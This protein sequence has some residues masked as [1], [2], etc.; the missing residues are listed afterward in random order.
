[1]LPLSTAS[2]SA[3]D[4]V[5][6]PAI[7]LRGTSAGLEIVVD[8]DAS[9]DAIGQ[10]LTD[11]L[12][13]SPGF[14]AGNDV[15]I[16]YEGRLPM[17][18]L[19]RLEQV[20]ARYGMRIA[21][22]GPPPRR[23]PQ[24][25]PAAEAVPVPIEDVPIVEAEPEP[26]PEPDPQPLHPLPAGW[27]GPRVLIGPVRSG[28]TL[29]AS[30]DL[31]ILGDVNPGAEINARGNIIVLGRLRGVAHAAIGGERGFIFALRLEPQQIRIGKMVARA[32]EA[33]R[34]GAGAEIAHATGKTI[35][36]ERYQGKVPI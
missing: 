29:D 1:M 22:V 19:A 25:P 13:Q 15:T 32:G 30:G 27:E 16:R 2:E 34:A 10:A 4:T 11:R 24:P 12:D 5:P 6:G 14:F 7:I 28:V 9:V 26:P 8:P 20:T 18:A 35:V 31:V 33:D 3:A 36:V 23:A 21:E 17:G